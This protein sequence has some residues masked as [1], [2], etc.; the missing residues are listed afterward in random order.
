MRASPRRSSSIEADSEKLKSLNR[1]LEQ[2]K[3]SLEKV[4]EEY[5]ASRQE[6]VDIET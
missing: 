5:K 3:E 2:Y 1:E 4:R 6:K